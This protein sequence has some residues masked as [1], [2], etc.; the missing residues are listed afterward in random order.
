AGSVLPLLRRTAAASP[1][2]QRSERGGARGDDAAGGRTRLRLFAAGQRVLHARF[3]NAARF[4]RGG[5]LPAS[6]LPR[7]TSEGDR[8]GRSRRRTLGFLLRSRAGERAGVLWVACVVPRAR[9][10]A[11]RR[12]A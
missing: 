5:S 6:R 9:G 2:A 3:S 10:R 8:A 12:P 7:I 4:R 1:V 11:R